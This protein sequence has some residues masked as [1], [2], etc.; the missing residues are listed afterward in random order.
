MAPGIIC[1]G[2]VRDWGKGWKEGL[3]QLNTVSK[4][5]INIK[6]SIGDVLFE[7]GKR[8][9]E[10]ENLIQDKFLLMYCDK[11]TLQIPSILS[12]VISKCTEKRE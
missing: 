12:K 10:A 4:F 7:T 1:K 3:F 8:S 9:K 6:Y 11:R 2:S 5:G